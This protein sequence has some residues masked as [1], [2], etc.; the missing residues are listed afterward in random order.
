MRRKKLIL[1]MMS[2][3]LVV[4][5]GTWLFGSQ[6][7]K[8]VV[9]P[10][11]SSDKPV[12]GA[13]GSEKTDSAPKDTSLWAQ[14]LATTRGNQD[15]D[16]IVASFKDANDC[17][18]YHGARREVDSILGDE[19]WNDLANLTPETL[20]NMDSSSERSVRIVQQ[21]GALCNGSDERQLISVA[22]EA[23]LTAALKGSPVAEA[24]F[25][26]FGPA[27]WQGPGYPV[28]E[29]MVDS[30]MQYA[31]EFTNKALENGDP[32]VAPRALHRYIASPPLHPSEID[33][34]P[35]ADPALTWRAARL[36]SLRAQPQ[37]RAVL[38]RDLAE[39][40]KQRLLSASDI[41]RADSWAKE[42]FDRQFSGQAPIDL[43]FPTQC[44]SSPGLAP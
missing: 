29:P 25:V 12:V 19:Q 43:D 17:L 38:E 22:R 34:L 23:V 5:L 40:A 9:S 39:F 2:I 35:K 13:P 11:I 6:V 4:A 26:L 42:T 41:A 21:L 14:K 7:N 18:L 27:S 15:L 16:S 20:K 8:P 10:H 37:Q 1:S 31:T 33:D 36:A 32:I 24:C 30:Y 3:I 28:M 44:Y